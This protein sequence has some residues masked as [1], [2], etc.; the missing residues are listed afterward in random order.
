M[1]NLK[2]YS[3]IFADLSQSAYRGRPLSFPKNQQNESEVKFDYS[4][5]LGGTNLPNNGIVYLQPDKT[6][7]TVEVKTDLTIPNPNGGYHTDSYVTGSYQASLLTDEKAG[8]NA[9]VVTDTPTLSADT[10]N[11]YLAIR[12][13]DAMTLKNWNDWVDNDANFALNNAHIPQAPLATEAMK[14]KIA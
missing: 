13:S 7:H 9:Y 8:F 4:A 2:S 6:L 1:S 12:G 10:Q 5:K 14:E 11:A 3:N